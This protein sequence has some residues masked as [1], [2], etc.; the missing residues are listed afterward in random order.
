MGDI[1]VETESYG[2]KHVVNS[3]PMPQQPFGGLKGRDQSYP[4]GHSDGNYTETEKV[5]PYYAQTTIV[6]A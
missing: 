4:Y 2:N 1:G 3:Q 5:N 6:I